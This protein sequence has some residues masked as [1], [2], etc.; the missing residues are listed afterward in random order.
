MEDDVLTIGHIKEAIRVLDRREPY[1][2]R[3]TVLPIGLYADIKSHFHITDK[4]MLAMGYIK[5]GGYIKPTYI[6]FTGE[7][8]GL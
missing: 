5:A 1:F 7:S 6:P 4:R 8:N 2:H 3:P